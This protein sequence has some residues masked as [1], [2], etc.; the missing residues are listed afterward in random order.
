MLY[1]RKFRYTYLIFALIYFILTIV[2]LWDITPD[3][4]CRHYNFIGVCDSEMSKKFLFFKPAMLFLLLAF[5]EW[6]IRH[7]QYISMPKRTEES[8]RFAQRML[9][10]F[11][12]FLVFL[13]YYMMLLPYK[14]AQVDYQNVFIIL[15]MLLL[16]PLLIGLIFSRK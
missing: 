15:F 11:K 4:V 16:S 12:Y 13:V 7:P 2:I 14:M 6:G 10:Y 3:K 1:D 9:A 8:I 5:M